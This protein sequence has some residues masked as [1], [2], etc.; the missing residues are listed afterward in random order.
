MQGGVC[1]GT[2]SN[3]KENKKRGQSQAALLPGHVVRQQCSN[4]CRSSTH[5]RWIQYLSP[6]GLVCWRW[7]LQVN[8]WLG[9]GYC[10]WVI[11]IFGVVVVLVNGQLGGYRWWVEGA[12]DGPSSLPC[13][14]PPPLPRL[15][16]HLPSPRFPR[17]R[18]FESLR[19]H[20]FMLFGWNC[21]VVVE[22][23]RRGCGFSMVAGGL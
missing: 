5:W 12:V 8:G 16:L 19:H 20:R 17:C 7:G 18:Q 14:A 9:G 10:L 1:I 22:L 21:V 2:C 11:V 6:L 4:L 23:R 13:P 15:A 3:S